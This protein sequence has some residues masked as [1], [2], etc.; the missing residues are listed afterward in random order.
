MKRILVPTDFSIPSKAGLRFAIQWSTQQRIELA[1]IHILNIN[2][3]TSWTDTY[4]QKFVSQE[5]NAAKTKLEKFVTNI[6]KSMKLKPG[7]YICLV[8]EGISADLQIINYCRKNPG[9][10]YICISTR[11]AGKFKKIIGTNTGNLITKSPIPVIAVPQKYKRSNISKIL[12]AT[13]FRD[14]STEMKKVLAFAEAVKSNLDV[15]HF[16]WTDEILLDRETTEKVL[17]REF[18]YKLKLHF[19]MTN[20]TLSLVEKLQSC[21]RRYKPSVVVMFTNQ[22]RNLIQKIFLPS[23]AEELS[24]TTNVPLLVFNK[25]NI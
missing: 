23:K 14:Y 6:Y 12:Y 25:G 7:K 21:I 2:K 15:L 5:L 3:L 11:G 10:D 9:I 22:G 18:K 4:I 20:G 17:Q 19:E 16:A 8:E 24:F 1:F 13:D